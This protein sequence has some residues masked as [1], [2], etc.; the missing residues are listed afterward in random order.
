MIKRNTSDLENKKSK[1]RPKI[2][3]HRG[4]SFFS[5]EN[6]LR[7]FQQAIDFGSDMVELDV[8]ITKD[9]Q[10]IVLH[11]TTIDRISEGTGMVK[12]FTLA[13]VRKLNIFGKEKIPTLEEVF[14][15]LIGKAK[16]VI[17]LKPA[18]SIPHL[19]RYLKSKKIRDSVLVSSFDGEIIKNIKNFDRKIAVGLICRMYR[20]K[21][22]DF[23]RQY[24]IDFIHPHHR[25]L[26]RKKIG[27]IKKSK[28]GV[29]VWTVNYKRDIKRV[30]GWDVD[31]IITDRSRMVKKILDKF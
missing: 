13:D 22:V 29:N 10:L 21:Y 24:K 14:D 25:F 3:A 28:L 31:G 15:F 4:A 9:D 30:L 20:K 18:D 8:Q 1:N 26:N 23:C 27:K 11:D 19:L 7:S 2:I 12:N 16:I 17:D 5:A 6:T